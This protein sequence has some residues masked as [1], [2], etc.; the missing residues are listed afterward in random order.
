MQKSIVL[1]ATLTLGTLSF[2]AGAAESLNA[3]QLKEMFT[4]KTIDAVNIEKGSKQSTYFSADGKSIQKTAD[5]KQ[6]QGTW[7]V[8]DK[9]QQCITWAGE[10]EICSTVSAKGDGTFNRIVG[11]KATVTI[12]KMRDGNQLDK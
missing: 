7:L 1:L 6:K 5:G 10:K 8:N 9:G 4:N 12:Q 2:Q 11:D 3:A